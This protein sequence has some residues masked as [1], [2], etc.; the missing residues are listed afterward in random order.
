MVL[1]AKRIVICYNNWELLWK[2]SS[3]KE[4]H[5]IYYV[6]TNCLFYSFYSRVIFAI[7]SRGSFIERRGNEVLSNLV[8]SERENE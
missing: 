8:T 4:D 7:T 2:N 1:E 5:D 3:V 6:N